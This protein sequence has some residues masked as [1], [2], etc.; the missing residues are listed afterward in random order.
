MLVSARW[1]PIIALV[2]FAVVGPLVGARLVHRRRITIVLLAASVCTVL[3]LTLVP[4]GDP[5]TAVACAVGLPYLSL[6]SVE[7]LSNVL[8]LAPT[9]LLAGVL[10][11]RPVAGAAG[12]IAVS[13]IVEATQALVPAIGR[14]CDTSDLLTNALGALV[15]GV[16]AFVALALARRRTAGA[17]SRV[18][19]S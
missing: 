3:G 4:D 14:A 18:S 19:T 10:L 7:S 2:G 9:A 11:R 17:A 13:A 1:L 15:G 16:L 8:L 5:S 6:T 12:A